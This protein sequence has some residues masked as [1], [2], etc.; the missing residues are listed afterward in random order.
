MCIDA[1]DGATLS[2]AVKVVVAYIDARPERMHERFDNLAL[3]ALSNRV[4]LPIA[5]PWKPAR[6]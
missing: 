6:A 2:Q 1:P 5:F 3:E 4:A